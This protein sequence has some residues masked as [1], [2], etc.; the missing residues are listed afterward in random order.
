MNQNIFEECEA[1]SG[2]AVLIN[3]L[4]GKKINI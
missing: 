1:Q 3:Q 4:P 2:G